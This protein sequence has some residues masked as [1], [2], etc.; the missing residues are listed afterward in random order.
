M[1]VGSRTVAGTESGV[2]CSYPC[3]VLESILLIEGI[4]I[5]CIAGGWII[6][7]F[8][9]KRVRRAEQEGLDTNDGGDLTDALAFVGAAFGI[10]LGLLLVFAVQHYNDAASAARTETISAVSAFHATAPFPEA[11][12]ETVRRD[13][14]CTM[15]SIAAD[16]FPAASRLET[17][18]SSVTDGWA[19]KLQ[20]ESANLTQDSP[21]QQTYQPILT[22]E[23]IEM[24]KQRQ[25]RLVSA[26]PSIPQ[27]IWLVIYMCTF[28]FSLLLVIH[29]GRR[30]RLAAVSMIAV[31]GV[32]L[33]IIGSLINLDYPFSGEGGSIKPE[34]MQVSLTSLQDQ[35]PSS[36]W[37]PCPSEAPTMTNS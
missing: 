35:Y 19:A 21:A 16:D 37:S 12:R 9:G 34:A 20:F 18:G 36:D 29:L 22:G 1:D 26:T 15:R 33:V 24:S 17:N 30:E 13:L 32:L 31:S 6:G 11:E 5:A 25:A 27:V 10:I 8:V 3:A 28:G 4:L 23:I 7:R 2:A 14:I